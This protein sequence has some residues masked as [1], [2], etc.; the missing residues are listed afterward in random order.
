MV[1]EQLP[2]EVLITVKNYLV[3]LEDLLNLR[4]VES[5]FYE[6]ISPIVWE[7][8]CIDLR[9]S[10]R[11][12][13]N[14][15]CTITFDKENMPEVFRS[16]ESKYNYILKRSLSFCRVLSIY[17]DKKHFST[18]DLSTT[19]ESESWVESFD[20]VVLEFIRTL[21]IST[22]SLLV[23][24]FRAEN[25]SK[26]RVSRWLQTISRHFPN[27]ENNVTISGWAP[28]DKMFLE[29]K[30]L[31]NTK[32]LTLNLSNESFLSILP[33]GKASEGLKSL[34]LFNYGWLTIEQNTLKQ[35]LSNCNNLQHLYTNIVPD[36]QRL[37]WVPETVTSLH[38]EVSLPWY[39][40]DQ[41]QQ[42]FT[43]KAPVSL[44]NIERMT[45]FTN[46]ESVFQSIEMENLTGLTLFL[47]WE[48]MERNYNWA[49]DLNRY[50]FSRSLN[51][52]HLYCEAQ[53]AFN[54]LNNDFG[55]SLKTLKI[56]CSQG[57]HLIEIFQSENVFK[58]CPN[59]KLL[60]L[61]M[62]TWRPFE[63]AFMIDWI[64]SCCKHLERIYFID[65]CGDHGK[66]REKYSQLIEDISFHQEIE[67]D[68]FKTPINS[69]SLKVDTTI[70]RMHG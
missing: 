24:N 53:T 10:R 12:K 70:Y 16:L 23:I 59:L 48:L 67:D 31:S 40:N 37:D 47:D 33:H 38:T 50:L 64:T 27:V 26:E 41:Q 20:D 2:V 66:E 17:L 29:D 32:S 52:Q 69:F 18:L 22:K 9:T 57:E 15:G 14:G 1:Y 21:G 63:I 62:C 39:Q 30:L 36:S 5:R 55:K 43:Y 49:K 34:S 19:S 46:S 35:F 25:C 45:V 51:I 65:Y 4:L 60:I 42:L 68:Y 7:N 8:I 58:F 56:D 11:R 61:V 3:N 28:L 44:P 6:I 13:S 54:I